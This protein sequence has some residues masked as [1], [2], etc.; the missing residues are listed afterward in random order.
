MEE[1]II[2]GR[3]IVPLGNS[4]CHNCTCSVLMSVFHPRISAYV[5]GDMVVEGSCLPGYFHS[6]CCRRI[7]RDVSD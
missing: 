3:R 2:A 5:S 4:E 7:V 1:V 6:W